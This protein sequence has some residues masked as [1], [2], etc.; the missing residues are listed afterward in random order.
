MKRDGKKEDLKTKIS[1]EK[2][3]NHSVKKS[4]HSS[5]WFTEEDAK[6]LKKEVIGRFYSV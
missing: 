1:F 4:S 2:K 6:K 5:G 3:Q